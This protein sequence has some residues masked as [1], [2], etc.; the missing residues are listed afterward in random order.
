MV[1]KAKS[2]TA[3]S[4]AAKPGAALQTQASA[5]RKPPVKLSATPLDAIAVAASTAL[6]VGMVASLIFFLVVAF[7]RGQYDSRLMYIFG[8]YTVA[9]VLIARIAIE[10]GRAYANAF[11]LPLAIV[12]I[13]AIMRFVT[14]SGPLGPLSWVVNIGLLAIAWYLADRITFDCTQVSDRQR[15]VRQGLLQSLGLLKPEIASRQPQL[16]LGSSTTT[17]ATAKRRAK[18][19]NPG[20]SVLY[21]ALLAFPLF[22][23][24]QLAIPAAEQRNQAFFFLIGYLACALSLLVLTSLVGMRRYL[25][26]RGVAMPAEMTTQWIAS[27]I[28]GIVLLL[29][30]C[31]LLPLPGRSLGLVG[32]P[33]FVQS[34]EGLSPSR[35]GWGKENPAASQPA[36]PAAGPAAPEDQSPNP[37]RAADKQAQAA[38]SQQQTDEAAQPQGKQAQGNSPQRNSQQ[39]R[40]EA[41]GGEPRQSQPSPNTS[42]SAQQPSPT[43]NSSPSQPA[44]EN[45]AAQAPPQKPAPQQAGRQQAER[46]QPSENQPSENQP[47]TDQQPQPQDPSRAPSPS[48]AQ[49]AESPAAEPQQT[50]ANQTEANQTEAE[51]TEAEQTEAEQTEA[52][53]TEAEQT[54]AEQTES[55]SAQQPIDDS[56]PSSLG[57]WIPRLPNNFADAFKWLTLAVLIVIIAIY[58]VM[59]PGDLARLWRELHAWWASLW[60]LRKP[61]SDLPLA[62]DSPVAEP[63]RRPFGSFINPFA[64]Q[65]NGWSPADVVVHTFAALEAWAAEHGRPRREQETAAEFARQV[66]RGVP[67]IGPHAQQAAHM[68]DQVMFA[69][70]H[71]KL[72]DVQPL[73]ALWQALSR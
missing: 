12:S 59:H 21:F 60:G 5:T 2:S 3:K 73:A 58:I 51:Q 25:R 65:L 53:Q 62:A 6:I 31:L 72:A 61:S 13:V 34:P 18:K 8:L 27:G 32:L 20:V 42:Q 48:A 55:Q 38:Q 9:T 1:R 41:G 52:E 26:Q 10:S 67:A 57:N 47:V 64:A 63:V 15:S 19:H 66:A 69:D 45:A 11:S 50:E 16:A 33:S 71:P 43:E 28:G 37:Q 4:V 22:G 14:F 49:P 54:E 30:L 40:A 46:P 68:L 56:S 35:W 17:A 23:L 44:A 39:D 7:Y 29:L 36:G 70:W 24:G